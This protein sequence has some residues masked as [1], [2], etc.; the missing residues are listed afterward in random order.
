MLNMTKQMR[1]KN[2]DTV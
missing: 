1:R 2:G